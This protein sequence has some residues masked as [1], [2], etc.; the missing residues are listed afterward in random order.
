MNIQY[1]VLLCAYLTTASCWIVRSYYDGESSC[2]GSV[3]EWGLIKENICGPWDIFFTDESSS[4]QCLGNGQYL[5][6]DSAWDLCDQ[7]AGIESRSCC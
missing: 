3:Y 1:L 2:T 6:Y 5:E 7:L 4:Y